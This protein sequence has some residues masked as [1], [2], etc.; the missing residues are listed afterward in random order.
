MRVFVTGGNG[1]IGSRVVR[2]LSLHGHAVR[3]LLRQTSRTARLEG[4]SYERAEGDV[5]DGASLERAMDSCDAVIHLASVSN[6]NDIQSPLMRTVVVEGTAHVLKAM[7]AR[8]IVRAV[9]ISSATAIN[10]SDRPQV[11]DERSAYALAG[12]HFAYAHAKREA[13]ELCHG[14]NAAGLSVVIANP[15]EVYGPGDDDLVTAGN[16]IDLVRSNPVLACTG[17]TSVVHVDDVSEGIVSALER[18][19]ANERYILGGENLTIRQI[20]ELSCSLAGVRRRIIVAPNV[21]IRGL[22]AL[23]ATLHLPLPFNPAVIPYATRFWFMDAGKA[24]RE[25]GV[26]FRSARDVLEPTIAWL[27]QSGRLG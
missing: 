3:L 17:G 5:R 14:A 20:A 4:L 2:A 21:L 16:L 27:R 9:Y 24:T 18:G 12:R 19:R 13:E 15:A 1:F 23:A 6:W 11:H 25:L 7:R 10:G 26:R 8:G 22:A